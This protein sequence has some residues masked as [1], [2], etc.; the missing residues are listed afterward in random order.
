MSKTLLIGLDGASFDFLM[1]W[2]EEGKLPVFK[3]ILQEGTHGI[4]NSTIPSITCPALPTIYTGMNPGNLGIFS[5]LNP[6]GSV[7]S[8]SNIPYKSIWHFLSENNKKSLDRKS[9]V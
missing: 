8:S 4:L 6:D 2:I 9:V 7:V 1:P 5:F 3:K